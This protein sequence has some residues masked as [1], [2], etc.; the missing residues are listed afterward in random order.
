MILV[1]CSKYPDSYPLINVIY[2]GRSFE[3]TV[4]G[5]TWINGNNG[6]SSVDLGYW[7][8]EVAKDIQPIPVKA[9]SVLKLSLSETR[10]ISSFKVKLIEGSNKDN[11]KVTEVNTQQKY[12][13]TTPKQKGEY[14][15]SVQAVWDE[16]HGV[17]YIFKIAVD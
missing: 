2:D 9:E 16:K 7:D 17:G 3:P 14:I 8:I 12:E 1:G 6:G 4:N 11:Q 15:Y 5:A 10:D 13:I